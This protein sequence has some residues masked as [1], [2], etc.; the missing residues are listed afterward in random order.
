MSGKLPPPVT[1]EHEYLAAILA[2]LRTINAQLAAIWEQGAA[3][4]PAA[5]G[6]TVEL[7]EKRKRG[8]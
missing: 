3:V 6:D 2:E 1:V 5:D 7:R 8:K 4:T